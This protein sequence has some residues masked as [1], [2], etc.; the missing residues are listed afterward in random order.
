MLENEYCTHA[1]EHVNI[2]G[3]KE[4]MILFTLWITFDVIYL[5]KIQ[6]HF[7]NGLWCKFALNKFPEIYI[8]VWQIEHCF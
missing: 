3:V 2:L 1:G 4:Y 7:Y 8:S 5:T 6:K